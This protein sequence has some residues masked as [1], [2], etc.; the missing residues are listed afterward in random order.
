MIVGI[1]T[2]GTINFIYCS[3]FELSLWMLEGHDAFWAPHSWRGLTPARNCWK[4]VNPNTFLT[5]PPKQEDTTKTVCLMRHFKMNRKTTVIVIVIPSSPSKYIVDFCCKTFAIFGG[6]QLAKSMPS[7]SDQCK[8]SWGA[9]TFHLLRWRSADSWSLAVGD[10]IHWAEWSRPNHH[11]SSLFGWMMSWVGGRVSMAH[12]MALD[13][14][15]VHR[16]C[17]TKGKHTGQSETM[18]PDMKP[19]HQKMLIQPQKKIGRRCIHSSLHPSA[20]QSCLYTMTP[21]KVPSPL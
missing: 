6:Q 16:W 17:G 18:F 11:L 13:S 5:H 10:V 21:K 19:T 9:A 2:K 20:S 3:F 15:F 14:V 7:C 4:N 1:A 8:P 12:C